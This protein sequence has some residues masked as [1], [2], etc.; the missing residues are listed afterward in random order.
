M[1]PNVEEDLH[2]FMVVLDNRY[3]EGRGSVAVLP[4]RGIG[5]GGDEQRHDVVPLA[6]R[7][8]MKEGSP[9]QDEVKA[10]AMRE[11]KLYGFKVNQRAMDCPPKRGVVVAPVG[12][13]KVG[14]VD[15]GPKV[16]EKFDGLVSGAETGFLEERAEIGASHAENRVVV[17]NHLEAVH[18]ARGGA[19]PEKGL[20]R[21]GLQTVGDRFRET[22]A[23]IVQE[24]K[25]SYGTCD[26]K[27]GQAYVLHRR[28]QHSRAHDPELLAPGGFHLYAFWKPKPHP[29]HTVASGQ[30]DAVHGEGGDGMPEQHRMVKADASEA[31]LV[32]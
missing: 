3:F 18:E 29:P 17:G 23:E 30:R 24:I 32:G 6:V 21:L 11:E 14:G 25:R 19:G 8:V 31:R 12:T 7:G 5:P 13:A 2:A 16:N 26:G 4:S 15:G 27:G 22:A 10:S 28:P 1:I 20:H 9:V